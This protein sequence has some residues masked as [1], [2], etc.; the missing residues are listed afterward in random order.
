MS[1]QQTPIASF[2]VASPCLPEEQLFWFAIQTRSRHEKKVSAELAEKGVDAFLPLYSSVR[3]WSDRK[4]IVQMPLF[5]QYVFVRIARTVESRI[6]VL[7]TNGVT[8]FVGTRGIGTAIPDPQIGRIQTVLGEG[9]SCNPHIF[10]NVGKRIRIKGGALDGVEGIL[11][12]VNGDNTLVVSVE[13]IQR[14]L[15]VR[16]TGFDIEPVSEPR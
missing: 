10:L 15:A 16:I 5:P 7:R 3:K 14:S 8:G 4:Q 2:R 6:S 1:C 12:R 11:T 9:I 13:L